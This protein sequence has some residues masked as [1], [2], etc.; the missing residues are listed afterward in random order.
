MAT[1]TPTELAQAGTAIAPVAAAASGGDSFPNDGNTILIVET[2]ATACTV[3]I[4]PTE[5]SVNISGVGPTTVPAI[6]QLIAINSQY[7]F[8]PFP[9]RVWNDGQGRVGVG[10][11]AVTNVT[12]RAVR[13][14][15]MS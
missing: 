1:L 7:A 4:N 14:P 2:G 8:G 13:V 6:S 5:S 3:S 15:R 12:V 11:S 9:P 10:Y